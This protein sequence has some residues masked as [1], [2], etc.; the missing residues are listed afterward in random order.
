MNRGGPWT[1]AAI[2]FALSGCSAEL[3]AGHDEPHGPLPVDE[4]SAVVMI[5]DGA[6]DN[7]QGEDAA[8]LD[9]TG[10]IDLVG[11]VV[12]KNAEY[13]S[14]ETNVDQYR[15]M[16]S[17]A[18]DSGMAHLP[19]AIASVA[20]AL[21]RPDSGLIE[22]TT[23]NRS[24]G[25]RFILQAAAQYARPEHPLAIATGG[26]LTD[27]ADAYLLDASVAERVVVV[28]SL[29]R[30]RGT[31]AIADDP[32][33]TRDSWATVIVLT[34]MAYVQVNGYYDQLLDLPE[35]RVSQLP[36]NAFG[37]WLA[38]K[39]SSILGLV[40]ACDQVSVL[41]IAWP[42][43]ASDVTRMQL[44]DLEAL[45]LSPHVDGPIWHVASTDSQR[46]RTEL[47]SRLASPETWK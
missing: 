6:L 37:R 13:P 42:W 38:Q 41:S 14:L 23:P 29:G 19:D 7:W 36:D 11:L 47:W 30:T 46:A 22:D 9:A 4:R 17:A 33:G 31:G 26:A 18:R 10:Q 39:R 15:Q 16:L 32:N 25:A 34:R 1:V 20:P 2:G 8:L 45:T 27:V 3:D 43:F 12:N 5:N 40:Q 21:V 24:E 35:E 28:A 44:Q